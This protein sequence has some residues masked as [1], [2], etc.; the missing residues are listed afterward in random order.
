MDDKLLRSIA[1]LR[2]TTDM[3]LNISTC[4]P[5]KPFLIRK[6]TQRYQK[7]LYDTTIPAKESLKDILK[8][9]V[10]NSKGF[11]IPYSEKELALF[12]WVLP[13]LFRQSERCFQQGIQIIKNVYSNTFSYRRSIKRKV[14]KALL[15]CYF[16]NYTTFSLATYNYEI[17]KVLK[18][19]VQLDP[20]LQS[21]MVFLKDCPEIIEANGHSVLTKLFSLGFSVALERIPWPVLLTYSGFVKK[22][23]V[24]YFYLKSL[25]PQQLFTFYKEIRVNSPFKDILPMLIGCMIIKADRIKDP[26]LCEEM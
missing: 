7:L 24:D 3:C 20:S 4:V 10:Y 6:F 9:A 19:I 8:K 25:A 5:Q 13:D 15:F 17:R 2:F 1:S 16:L 22:A 11:Y 21:G 23:I 14:F 18:E 12:P 26:K